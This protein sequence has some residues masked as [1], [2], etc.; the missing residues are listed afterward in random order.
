LAGNSATAQQF[1]GTFYIDV[2]A[3]GKAEET[4]TGHDPGDVVAYN[5]VRRGVRLVRNIITHE[6]YMYLDLRGVVTKRRFRSIEYF[7]PQLDG[8]FVQNVIAYRMALDVTYGEFALSAKTEDLNLIEVT[9]TPDNQVTLPVIQDF[10]S[11]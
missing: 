10:V 4:D 9:L 1:D 5:N 7:Q 2:Y 3:Y 11:S 8:Q 6:D